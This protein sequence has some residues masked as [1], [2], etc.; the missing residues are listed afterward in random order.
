LTKKKVAQEELAK[1]K[2]V[3]LNLLAKTVGNYVHE[4]VPVSGSEDDNKEEKVWAPEGVADVTDVKGKLS[5][6]EVRMYSFGGSMGSMAMDSV[7]LR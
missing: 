4:S 3:Q 5:H 7:D 6:H 2:L 1:A